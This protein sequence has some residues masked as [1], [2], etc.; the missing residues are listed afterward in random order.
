MKGKMKM[1]SRFQISAATLSLLG[2]TAL[3]I[4]LLSPIMFA[5]EASAQ[6]LDLYAVIVGID[7]YK[8]PSDNLELA[9]K[10]AKDI[11]TFLNE[12]RH[13]FANVHIKLL[14]DEKA[15]RANVVRAFKDD[16]RPAR[17]GDI[18][19]VYLSGHGMP[20]KSSPGNYYF[21]S[22]DYEGDRLAATA[23]CMSNPSLFGGI[24]SER[25]LLI[26]DAC[27]SGG[28]LS[29][30]A[31]GKTPPRELLLADFAKVYGR[32][33]ISAAGPKEIA[34]EERRFGNGLF[35]F[36]FLRGIRGS[37]DR[38]NDGV[39]TVKE[40]FDYA[41]SETKKSTK[42][43]QNPQLYCVKGEADKTP[44]YMVPVY[45]KGLNIEM[46]FFYED[47]REQVKLL[48]E[49]S[50]LKSGQHLGVAFKPDADCFVHILWWDSSGQVGRLFPNPKLTE[51][52]GHVKGGETHWLPSKEGGKHWFVLDDKPGYETVYF[53]ASRER[54]PKLE[55]LYEELQALSAEAK[56]SGRSDKVAL[57][58]EREINLMGFADYTVPVASQQVAYENREKLFSE[59]E[60]KVKVT[61]A[62]AF[63]KLRFK[64]ETR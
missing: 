19:L 31:R 14:L 61:G 26:A 59:M 13:L 24:Q 50:V 2:L 49:D 30:L 62:E 1:V 41:S 48:T 15:T 7:K 11:G 42:G 43:E 6:K 63:F 10:D 44:V 47:E 38:D 40:L 28:Y 9:A 33:G 64:H 39:V 56:T 57:E 60:S 46:K 27:H 52:T 58:I 55:K 20:D 18:V 8:D 29:G 32:F 3:L 36:H 45:S 22:H 25:V 5:G 54:N 23:V 4:G 35:T 16:L 34:K 12:R 51:G 37:A 21:C 17:R 53:V